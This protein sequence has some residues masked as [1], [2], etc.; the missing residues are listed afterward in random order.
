MAWRR[1]TDSTIVWGDEHM[2]GLSRRGVLAAS[3]AA[4]AAIGATIARA[5]SFGNPDMPPDG[6]VNV[7]TPQ[8]LAIPGPH[9]SGLA[10][11]MPTFLSPPPTDVGS[12][13]QFWA[14]FNPSFP[15]A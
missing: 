15:L 11:Q 3:A 4:G 7:T 10:D 9:D 13:P 5:A 12:M 2:N 14:S 6:A 1:V 8:A